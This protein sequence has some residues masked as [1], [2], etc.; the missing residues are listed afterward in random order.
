MDTK[1]L[2]AL[3]DKEQLSSA[4]KS[5]IN[6]AYQ[7]KFQRKVATQ[8]GCTSCYHDAIIEL[9]AAQRTGYQLRGGVVIEYEGELYTRHSEVLPAWIIENYPDKLVKTKN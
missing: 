5:K 9:I 3:L 6:K 1:A 8:T 7:S 4:D 2:K